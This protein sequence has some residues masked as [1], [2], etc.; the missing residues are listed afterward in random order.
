[1]KSRQSDALSRRANPP[2]QQLIATFLWTRNSPNERKNYDNYTLLAQLHTNRLHKTVCASDLSASEQA[3][4]A[5]TVQRGRPE[6]LVARTV[7][8]RHMMAHLQS[9][10]TSGGVPN[11]LI[12]FRN[13]MT[14]PA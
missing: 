3:V 14:E 7:R 9:G 11:A 12:E 13:A 1:M 10:L 6:W 5:V 4:S 2:H 8:K